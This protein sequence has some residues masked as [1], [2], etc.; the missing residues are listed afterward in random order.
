MSGM[1]LGL[2]MFAG[3][4]AMLVLRVQVGVAMFLAG[5]LCFLVINQG[6]LGA[7][8]YTLNNLAYA[9][10]SNYDLA[11]IP[12]FVLMGQFATHGGLSK[13]LFRCASAFIGHWRGGLA[14]SAVGACAG[15]GAICG[16]SL[17]TAATM[18]QV[19][20]P[21]LARHKY[22]GR[23]ATASV[24]AGGT[25]GILIP[26]SVPL[27][28]YAVLTQESIAKLFVAAMLPALVA[29][30]G[31]MLV[32]RIQVARD[33][34]ACQP[35]PKA[36]GRERLAAFVQILPI[37]AIF[38][39]VIV[40]IYGGWA[41]P[42]EA[43]SIGAAACGLLAALRGGMRWDGLGKSL[44]GTAEASAMIFLVLLG[45]DLLNS[46]LALTQ[47]PVEL[48]T[49][50]RDSGLAPLLVL[51]VIL[52]IY[53][54]LGCVMDSLAMILLTIPIF[55]PMI[56]GL[57]FFDLTAGEKSIWFGI[58]ALMVVEIGLI[59][60]PLGMNLF[61]VNKLAK[62]VP[63]METARG[64]LPFLASDLLRIVLLVLVPGLSL[65]LLSF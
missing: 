3:L 49:W 2:W 57:E 47:M 18:G 40:G 33:P 58:L 50:V 15:F 23:L 44:T 59:H 28:I 43:A 29:V 51:A 17:A 34:N 9:R 48:A 14:L 32:I 26:P 5:A 39:V 8:L 19:A 27:I 54:L 56:M 53:L 7:L 46:G 38:L 35:A 10:L 25:L 52:L 55:Y 65:W 64:V 12:L 6:D 45:A 42:T 20:L 16:S 31:Y 63:Y 1:A 60:P 61:I 62:D 37:L 4:L 13:A 41:N 24:A 11:V 22:S 30:I 36:S 21:E